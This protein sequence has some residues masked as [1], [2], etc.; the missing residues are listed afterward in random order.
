MGLFLNPLFSPVDLFVC[1]YANITLAPSLSFVRGLQPG[2]VGPATWFFS[3]AVLA[4]CLHFL[5]NFRISF[6]A[7]AERPAGVM[8]GVTV[9][10]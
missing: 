5:I 3:K 10:L 4:P 6:S 7:S 9:N 8:I 2:S 1:L